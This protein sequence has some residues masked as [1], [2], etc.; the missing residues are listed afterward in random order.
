VEEVYQNW[1]LS[2]KETLSKLGW[3]AIF[4]QKRTPGNSDNMLGGT[5]TLE[6]FF[7]AFS[8]FLYD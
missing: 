2:P 1:A 7:D 3:E 6:E 4:G 8:H 5:T